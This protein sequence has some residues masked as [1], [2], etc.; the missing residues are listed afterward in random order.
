VTADGD[1]ERAVSWAALREVVRASSAAYG[2]TLTV[3]TTISTLV[4]REGSPGTGELFLFAAGGLL[5]FAALD[6]ALLATGENESGELLQAALPLAAALNVLAV[7]VALGAATLLSR[8]ISGS[9]AWLAC[10]FAATLLYLV[11]LAGQLR[12]VGSMRTR[13]R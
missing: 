3:A 13:G 12:L 10:P 1:D 5:A 8:A 4:S 9:I 11:V 6:L 2:Y 7:G